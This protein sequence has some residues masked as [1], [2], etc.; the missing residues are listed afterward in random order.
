MAILRD[1]E[2]ELKDVAKIIAYE[3]SKCYK[4]LKK[5]QIHE[6]QDLVQEGNIVFLRTYEKYNPDGKH[7]FKQFFYPSLVHRF[8]DMLA[9]SYKEV[10][11]Q[12]ELIETSVWNC[13]ARLSMIKE[14]CKGLSEAAFDYL[15]LYT[16]PPADLQ[17]VLV[18]SVKQK[19]GLIR[20]YLGMSLRKERQIKAE[21]LLAF[22]NDTGD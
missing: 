19:H 17:Y 22:K 4:L 3:A 9:K 1:M 6:I 10:N 14:C 12:T 21:I 8:S 18:H 11:C 15:H 16:D 20:K 7:T 2:T 5:P 13:P